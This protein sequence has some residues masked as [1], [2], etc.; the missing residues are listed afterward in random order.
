MPTKRQLRF[1]QRVTVAAREAKSALPRGRPVPE[2]LTPA[3]RQNG[4]QAM[5][6]APRCT[7]KRKD[8]AQCRAMA[9]R[10]A[11]RCVKHGGRAE[12][13][14]HPHNIRRFLSGAMQKALERQDRFNEGRVAWNALTPRAQRELVDSLGD[15]VAITTTVLY[16]A[17]RLVHLFDDNQI[18]LS[19]FR[20]QW[21][22]I[23]ASAS[24]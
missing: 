6:Q 13:P 8:G 17:A 21:Q 2:N 11:T 5:R 10:G 14:D 23:L 9:L 24:A 18:T 1:L 12:V 15:D 16:S 22:N 4:L 7:A 19:A 3:G 20:K